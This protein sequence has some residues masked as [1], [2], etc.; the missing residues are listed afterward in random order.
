MK[1]PEHTTDRRA[2]IIERIEVR[3]QRPDHAQAYR[4]AL[5]GN[6]VARVAEGPL[7][8][9]CIADAAIAPTNGFGHLDAGIDGVF[10]RRFGRRTQRSL[11]ERIGLE[12]DGELP[13]G[14]AII[15]ATGDLALPFMVAAPATQFPAS[16]TPEP[17]LY[18]SI[19]AALDALDAWN[20]A[21]EGPWIQSV[22]LP[23]P[24]V[25]AR[26]WDV[27]QLAM[28]LSAALRDWQRLIRSRHA[29]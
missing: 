20:A 19:R 29:A 6:P 13:V 2:P 22:I 7:L 28:Q 18:R 10:A 3:T 15:L 12:F 16:I 11:Q 26:S 5:R 8:E 1:A 4:H 14:N 17:M 21:D 23:D 25:A 27:G 9:G 24:A